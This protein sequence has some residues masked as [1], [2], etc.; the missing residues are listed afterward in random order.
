MAASGRSATGMVDATAFRAGSIRAIVRLRW[1]RRGCRQRTEVPRV[2]REGDGGDDGVGRG[3]HA[4]DADPGVDPHAAIAG[5]EPDA[6]VGRPMV[7]E[8]DR[9]VPGLRWQAPG[10][11]IVAARALPMPFEV[12]V[13]SSA[14]SSGLAPAT[15][16]AAIAQSR[17][18][19]ETST[20][21]CI[22]SR[23]FDRAVSRSRRQH[24]LPHAR[25][26]TGPRGAGRRAA[27]GRRVATDVLGEA[28]A[29][30]TGEQVVAQLGPL[31]RRQ[32]EVRAP[33]RSG[34]GRAR[35]GS[36]RSVQ[37]AIAQGRAG[38]P[39]DVPGGPLG[40]PDRL[41]DLLAAEAVRGEQEDRA[42]LCGQVPQ[43]AVELLARLPAE[44]GRLGVA[45]RVRRRIRPRICSQRWAT[46]AGV[47]G[48]G[49]GSCTR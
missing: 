13:A 25:G 20:A 3:V 36:W 5:D 27:R 21:N 12:W 45:R 15:M 34:C 26:R 8:P 38:P 22:T 1:P 4:Q 23:G 2:A 28:A 31:G 46:L 32:A 30:R 14:R 6:A 41:R 40:P 17:A 16:S 39:Q 9:A 19:H 10:V 7:T 18:D 35:G 33:I 48:S 43:G 37:K 11:S 42:L 29:L 49:Q 44:D 24:L 47:R